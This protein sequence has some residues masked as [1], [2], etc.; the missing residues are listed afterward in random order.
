M[1]CQASTDVRGGQGALLAEL[2]AV[3]FAR[4]FGIGFLRCG[5]SM[6]LD[7]VR[8]WLP[9][10]PTWPDCR[11]DGRRQTPIL[12]DHELGE[13]DLL[14][15]NDAVRGCLLAAESDRSDG[16]IYNIAAGRATQTEDL[17]QR[18]NALLGTQI[19]PLLAGPCQCARRSSTRRQA[20][21]G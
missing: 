12:Y 14:D 17:V 6:S 8:D 7:S 11:S 16:R 4:S 15:V 1:S 20:G 3:S 5:T 18:L 21:S 2:E 13:H 19:E 10:D 9:P